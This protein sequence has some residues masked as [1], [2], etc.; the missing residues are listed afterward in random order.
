MNLPAHSKI[1]ASSMKRWAACPGSVKLS[2]GIES[3]SSVFAEEGT[4]AHELAEKWLNEGEHAMA[5]Y[6]VDMVEHVSVY[7]DAVMERWDAGSVNTVLVEQR[8]HLHELHS[9]LFGTSDAIV[10]Q[11]AIERLSVIDLKYGA[12][13]PVEVEDN[14]QLQYYA[15]GALLANKQWKPR[16]VEV[17]IVQPRCPHPDGPV[18]TQ[19]LQ[20][21]DLLD[22]AADLVEAVKR[23]EEASAAYDLEDTPSYKAYWFELYLTL[24]DHCRFCPAAAIC[25]KQ[26]SNAQELAKIAFTPGVSYDAQQLA[27][28]LEWLPILEAWIKNTREFAYAEAEKGHDIP[29]HKLVEK[30]ATR[31][32]RDPIEAWKHLKAAGVDYSEALEEPALKSPAAIEKLLP[33]DKRTILDELTVKESSGHTL[34]HESDKREAIKVDAKSAF[35]NT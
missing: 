33:K 28:T 11:P 22:F 18:R 12:G 32:W 24:G 29:R 27:D 14:P 19:V 34:V 7:I 3:R 4:K 17:V 9:D 31:K 5:G 2:E 25:P 21:V 26:R 15:L 13:V 8:F 10:W 35:A 23:T 30:R 6:P 16:E 1:G 20:V